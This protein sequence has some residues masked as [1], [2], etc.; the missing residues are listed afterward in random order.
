VE[1]GNNELLARRRCEPNRYFNF[2]GIKRVLAAMIKA[3]QEVDS[4]TFACA[5]FCDLHGDFR[6]RR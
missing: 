2:V 5:W 4:F 3:N 1:R 6:Q